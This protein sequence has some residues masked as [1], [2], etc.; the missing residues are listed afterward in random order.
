M[1]IA[2]LNYCPSPG[3]FN[4]IKAQ[5][6]AAQELDLDLEFIVLSDDFYSQTKNVKFYR[7][8][9]PQ[10]L[11]AKRL[12]HHFFRY[13][14]LS[15]H[16]DLSLYDRII[17]RYPSAVALS[18][19]KFFKKYPIITEH[20][21]DTEAELESLEIGYLNPLRL[22]LEKHNAPKLLSCVRGIIGLTDEIRKKYVQLTNQSIPSSVISNGIQVRNF[23]LTRFKKFDGK[24]LN[25]IFISSTFYPWQGLDRLLQGLSRYSGNLRINLFLAGIISSKKKRTLESFNNK[26][27]HIHCLGLLSRQGLDEY[28]KH[29]N[30]AVS[31][32]ALYRK[33][34]NEACPLKTREYTARG[35]PFVFA[36]DDVDIP[37]KMEFALKLPNTDSLVDISELIQF[38]EKT[39]KI[40]DLSIK[41]RKFAE[42]NMDW[43]IKIQQMYE[44][45]SRIT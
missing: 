14:I 7:I 26:N 36:Y 43:K 10:I 34:M 37:E 21:S 8:N 19:K 33:N 44:L 18:F 24:L 28:F 17:L 35:I 27:L 23:P 32:L 39:S 29:S 45:V 2:H 38:A 31:T 12:I 20:H 40:P 15:S 25:I 16:V 1:K 30:I 13:N 6:Q 41:M 5:A 3:V 22:F 11:P 42:N 9:L 4:K